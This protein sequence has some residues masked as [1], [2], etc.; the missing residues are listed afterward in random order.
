M[1]A[2]G[3]TS[4]AGH[5]HAWWIG[6]CPWLPLALLLLPLGLTAQYSGGQ[7]RGDDMVQAP[8]TPC[9]VLLP[10]K[11]LYF[12]ATCIDGSAHLEWATASER[13][14][15]SFVAERATD[16]MDWEPIG[17][18]AAAGYSTSTIH[19]AFVDEHPPLGSL[20]YYRVRQED[21]DGSGTILPTLAL[22]HCG[23]ADRGLHVFPNP[24]GDVIRVS[25]PTVV[26][27]H[28]LELVD[29][30]GRSVRFIYVAPTEGS[31]TL[32]FPLAGIAAGTYQLV[33]RDGQ[34]NPIAWT[35]VMK[36]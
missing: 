27:T 4:I 31:R 34:G 26:V 16:T 23:G 15:A 32:E 35:K 17:R 28:R 8:F 25:I 33:L 21:S 12:R 24:A 7:G 30:A 19:Y 3:K 9:E 18:L 2:T 22:W 5:G 20:V 11:L 13:N 1:I 6:V 36:R 14:S 29:A 10:V